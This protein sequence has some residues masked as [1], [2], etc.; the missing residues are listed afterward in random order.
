M[1]DCLKYLES[2]RKKISII[3]FNDN[4]NPVNEYKDDLERTF[5]TNRILIFNLRSP[6]KTLKE[7]IE[8]HL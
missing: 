2:F 7:D 8:N 6:K 4:N 3:I 5:D 1:I